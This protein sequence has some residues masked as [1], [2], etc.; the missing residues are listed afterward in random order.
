MLVVM[1]DDYEK[2]KH[3]SFDWQNS[4]KIVYHSEIKTILHSYKLFDNKHIY[5]YFR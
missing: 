1:N 4:L 5:A 2:D 3:N